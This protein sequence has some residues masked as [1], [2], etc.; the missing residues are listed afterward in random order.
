MLSSA[1]SRGQID[2]RQNLPATAPSPLMTMTREALNTWRRV[3][4]AQLGVSLCVQKWWWKQDFSTQIGIVWVDKGRHLILGAHIWGKNVSGSRKK[5]EVE[6]RREIEHMGKASCEPKLGLKICPERYVHMDP[7]IIPSLSD[8][9][10]SLQGRK[11]ISDY[12]KPAAILLSV[13]PAWTVTDPVGNLICYIHSI[14]FLGQ[15][16]TA[17]E[18]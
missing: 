2:R 1:L 17:Q 15:I 9:V 8:F 4:Q 6:R 10:L 18:K 16:L 13:P 7:C 3:F 12:F 5:G 11:S 14:F